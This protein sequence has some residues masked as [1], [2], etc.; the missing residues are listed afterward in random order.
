LLNFHSELTDDEARRLRTLQR[1]Q[2][3]DTPA[4]STYDDIAQLARTLCNAPISLI[5]FVAQERQWFKARHGL[6]LEET[7]RA[8]SFCSHAIQNPS[9]LLVIPDTHK[10]PRFA[11]SPLVVENTCIRFYAG[12]PLVTDE[13]E[14]LGALCIMDH[15]PR[16]L[17]ESQRQGLL[18]LA[19]NVVSH[20]ELYLHL[21]NQG[22]ILQEL[23][24]AQLGVQEADDRFQ[25]AVAAMHD[26][27][28]VHELN[29]GIVLCNPR[30]E[31]LLGLPQ[32]ELL[33]RTFADPHWMAIRDDGKPFPSTEHPTVVT[34]RDGVPQEKVIMGLHRSDGELLWVSINS[35]P[36]FHPNE[37]TPYA[38]VATFADISDQRHFEKIAEQ[39]LIEFNKLN[40]QLELRQRELAQANRLLEAQAT[41]DGLTGL[42][43]HRKF[44]EEI[45]TQ[46]RLS[47]RYQHPLSLILLDV[48][49]FKSYNDT[50]GHPAGDEV[51][52]MIANCLLNATRITDCAARYGGEEFAIILPHTNT[53][54]SRIVA[55]RCRRV[56]AELPWQRRAVTISVGIATMCLSTTEPKELI[57]QADQA[58]Y[59]SK[60]H[61]KN[62]V[63]HSFDITTEPLQAAA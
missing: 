8:W 59:Y 56:I 6:E 60:N 34:L 54:D 42:K 53:D 62:C 24:V 17:T 49:S 28:I 27:L 58:L 32:N 29:R 61:G 39:Q 16:Q 5:S 14:A 50:F 18:V 52:R 37:A 20:L 3:L 22:K 25:S 55:E 43:N 45:L 38:A 31:A 15:R 35:A 46:Y 36:L 13:G 57:E 23:F 4:E 11:S 1:Y 41:I 10:D 21:Q 30:A 2:I 12:A 51:L 9:E 40:R 33:G 63:T 47:A 7:P 19:R 44:Q 48:D 26:G